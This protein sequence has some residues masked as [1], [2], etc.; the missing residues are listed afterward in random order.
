[1]TYPYE[2]ASLPNIVDVTCPS[3]GGYAY[4]R[5]VSV[6][7]IELKSDIDYF[8]ESDVFEY[9][10]MTKGFRQSNWHAAIYYHELKQKSL[11]SIADL[12]DGYSASD[13]D[14]ARHCRHEQP[15]TLVCRDCITRHKWILNWPNDAYYQT[16]LRGEVLWAYDR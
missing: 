4:F 1:M 7:R 10:F 14:R 6:V 11:E 12:P 13:W 5:P 9:Q 2:W 8:E 3:C 15:G 16:D